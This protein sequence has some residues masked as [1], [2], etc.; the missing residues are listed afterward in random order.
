MAARQ[1]V[2]RP[3]AAYYDR[4]VN[5]LNSLF[6]LTGTACVA[7]MGAGCATPAFDAARLPALDAAIAL[8]VES[9]K[10]P[11]AA[12]HLE[13]RGAVHEVV[14]GK[15][16]YDADAPAVVA[17][18]VFDAASLTKVI[19]TAPSILLLAEEGKIDLDAPLRTWFPDCEAGGL[20]GIT[21]RQLLT[22]NSGLPAGIPATPPWEGEEAAYRLACSRVL[23]HAPGTAFRYSDVNFILLGRLVQQVSGLTLDQFAQQ[24]L[25]GPLGMRD[26]GFRPLGRIA[27]ARIAP[28]RPAA[29]F[30]AGVVHDP[31]ARRMGGVGGS[32]G[33]FTTIGDVARYARMLLGGGRHEGRQI[34][35]ADSVRLMSTVQSPP[36]IAETRAMGMDIGSPFARPRG[37]LFPVGSFG[38]TGYTGCVLWIDAGSGTFYVFLSN[39]VYPD[40]KSDILALYGELGTLA[41]RALA[42]VDFSKSKG[43]P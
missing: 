40:E 31:T 26:T 34:L 19:A 32:A 38:H 16:S 12:F 18:T 20:G 7:A 36:G 37:E 25:F 13:R 42:G 33:V 3:P 4:M 35:H 21:V 9:G 27:P 5:F 1:L 10:L 39:R 2:D 17:D 30:A 41:A 11:G 43:V 28:T 29:E 6:R 8:A 23:S 14:A 22:H 24:R 15:L